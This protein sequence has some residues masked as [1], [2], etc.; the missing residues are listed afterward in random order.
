MEKEIVMSNT[1]KI[2]NSFADSSEITEKDKEILK[3]LGKKFAELSS[4]PKNGCKAEKWR[5]LND[6]ENVKPMVW[7]S[8]VPWHEMD[9]NG[10]LKPRVDHP[11]LQKIEIKIRRS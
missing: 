2:P 8:D 4:D 1:I 11:I 10:E 6:L 3:S 5:R 9:V 7:I